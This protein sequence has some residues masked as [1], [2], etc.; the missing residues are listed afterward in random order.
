[1]GKIYSRKDLNEHQ[2]KDYEDNYQYFKKIG[3]NVVKGY[4]T[5]LKGFIDINEFKS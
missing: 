3:S 4:D 2:L 1:M 5:K